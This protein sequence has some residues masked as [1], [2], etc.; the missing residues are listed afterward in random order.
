MNS[1]KLPRGCTRL[2]ALL[3]A[4]T[5]LSGSCTGT[6][7]LPSGSVNVD[8]DVVN[9]DLPGMTLAIDGDHFLLD[10]PGVEVQADEDSVCVDTPGVRVN[11][12]EPDA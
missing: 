1:H 3:V 4:G 9:V 5:L 12:G 11:V 2:A 10:L 7:Y 6:F 8:G